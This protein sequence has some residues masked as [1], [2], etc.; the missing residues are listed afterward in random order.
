MQGLASR[1]SAK[2]PEEM[3]R[4]DRRAPRHNAGDGGDLA[5]ALR[6]AS[7]RRA[8]GRAASGAPRTVSDVTVAEFVTATLE[9]LPA[10]RT[11]WISRTMAKAS[12]VFVK[13][14]AA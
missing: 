8:P 2:E 4:G 6:G 9:S 14:V 7:P 10:G 5:Q 3:I 13:V 11:H 12:A 1:L